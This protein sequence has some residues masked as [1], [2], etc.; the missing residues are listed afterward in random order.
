ML[1]N[2]NEIKQYEVRNVV[3]ACYYLEHIEQFVKKPRYRELDKELVLSDLRLQKLYSML[4]L[5]KDFEDA[6]EP[7]VLKKMFVY[8]DTVNQDYD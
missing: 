7:S 3:Q 6:N 1:M 8:L 2:P 5:L 4:G